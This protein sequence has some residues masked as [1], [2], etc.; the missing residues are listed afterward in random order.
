MPNSWKP[1]PEGD[2]DLDLRGLAAGDPRSQAMNTKTAQWTDPVAY[3]RHALAHGQFTLFCQPIAAIARAEAYPMAETLI[4]LREEE[5]AQ[6]PPGL[7]TA[8][9]SPDAA[10]SVLSWTAYVIFIVV[11]G[12]IGRIE[13]PI[14]GVIIFY[15]MQ[16][17]LADFGTWYLI[18]LGALAI[19]VMLFAPKGIWGYL[20]D[21]FG[22]VLFPVRRRL[23]GTPREE[24]PTQKPLPG[25]HVLGSG[26]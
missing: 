18:L 2:P 22:I 4:R 23:V 7:V 24:Y 5:N 21:R 6:L 14:V 17:Y 19:G 11:I 9:I 10:F 16:S 3:L 13:G 26:L 1:D 12:G 25:E 20:S 15:L 8:R